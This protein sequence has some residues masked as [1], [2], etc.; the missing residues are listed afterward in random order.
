MCPDDECTTIRLCRRG[1]K[2]GVVVLATDCT[3]FWNPAAVNPGDA[4]RIG[5]ADVSLP[6]AGVTREEPVAL[7]NS[8]SRRR[9]SKVS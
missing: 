5:F 7:L 3:C 2:D 8:I 4:R 1:F 6:E 9:L